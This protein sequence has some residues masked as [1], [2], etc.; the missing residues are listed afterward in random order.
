M[1]PIETKSWNESYRRRMIDG[2][3]VIESETQPQGRA[4]WSMN[5]VR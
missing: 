1:R 4:T 2:E 5:V 3:M